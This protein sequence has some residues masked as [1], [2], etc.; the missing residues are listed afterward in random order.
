MFEKMSE[1]LVNT[2]KN[3]RG[4]KEAPFLSYYSGQETCWL[5]ILTSRGTACTPLRSVMSLRR[6]AIFA[7]EAESTNRK[8]IFSCAGGLFE[9]G[10]QG[11]PNG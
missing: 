10:R 1:S 9:G 11:K 6:I 5:S 4:K 2:K 3:G 7:S 8:R